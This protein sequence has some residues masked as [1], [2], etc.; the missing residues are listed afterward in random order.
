MK[1]TNQTNRSSHP[2]QVAESSERSTVDLLAELSARAAGLLSEI[3][4]PTPTAVQAAQRTVDALRTATQQHALFAREAARIAV[5][6]EEER[7]KAEARTMAEKERA[8]R[9]HLAKLQ[10]AQQ[11]IA[12]MTKLA[13]EGEALGLK[14]PTAK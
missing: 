4:T 9:E 7:A 14:T 12:L 1:D 10:D 13:A 6:S 11:Q 8:A 3:P 5:R 2:S